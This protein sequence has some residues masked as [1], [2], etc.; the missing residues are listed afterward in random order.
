MYRYF[1]MNKAKNNQLITTLPDL[2]SDHSFLDSSIEKLREEA[3]ILFKLLDQRSDDIRKLEHLLIE[4]KAFSPFKI[5][6]KEEEE[7][8]FQD[9]TSE[10]E[11]KFGDVRACHTQVRRYLSWESDDIGKKYRLFLIFIETEVIYFNPPGH[12]PDDVRRS[13]FRSKSIF[14]KPVIETD[15]ATRL[16]CYKHLRSFIDSF[17]EH[18]KNYRISIQTT[19][20]TD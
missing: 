7:L 12:D 15:I 16:E 11:K 18:L 8:P 6:I 19:K 13:D 10:H 14:K 5:C 2:S 1:L 4:L 17:K 3:S 9:I 20:I